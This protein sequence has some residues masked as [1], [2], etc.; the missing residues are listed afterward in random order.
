MAPQYGISSY[1]GPRRESPVAL[2]ARYVALLDALS[3]IDP[4]FGNWF[5]FGRK[6]GT[7]LA[8]LS[9]AEI[10][11][12]IAKSVTRDDYGKPTPAG[13]YIFGAGNGLMK[14]PRHVTSMLSVGST[15]PGP[16]YINCITLETASLN[17]E[18]AAFINSHVMKQ[19]IL[20]IASTWEVTWCAA[21]PSDLLDHWREPERKQMHFKLAWITFVSSR[22]APMIAPPASAISERLP[23]GGLLMLATEERFSTSNPAHLAVARDIEASLAP[24]NALPW[25]PDAEPRDG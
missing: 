22:F 1:W 6:K 10:I 21:Y 8:P 11:E 9:R 18:N 24:L 7:R 4:V 19:A 5:F 20:A 25:P 15:F 13:G 12:L 3:A 16:Y 2:A 14:E 17:A 23:D